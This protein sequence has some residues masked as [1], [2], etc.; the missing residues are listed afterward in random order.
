MKKAYR[1]PKA[2]RIEYE[3]ENQVVA[4]SATCSGSHY[5]FQTTSGCNQYKFT[6]YQKTRS[7][8]PCDWI[9]QDEPFPN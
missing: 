8:H 7:S 4:A 9:I 6:D 5:V 3:Y 2:L 1:T